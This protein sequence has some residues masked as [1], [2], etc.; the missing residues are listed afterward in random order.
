MCRSR[1]DCHQANAAEKSASEVARVN[2]RHILTLWNIAV[3]AD[4]FAFV[5]LVSKPL[6]WDLN[7][8]A[9]SADMRIQ[10]IL[11]KRIAPK[12]FFRSDPSSPL[13][14][15][16]LT[17]RATSQ[18]AAIAGRNLGSNSFPTQFLCSGSGTNSFNLR[19]I[20]ISGQH[21]HTFKSCRR[22]T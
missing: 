16:T 5:K 17:K 11:T 2:A 15:T 8:P 6:W 18:K 10:I 7:K 21:F 12:I 3:M 22:I 20:A 14:R 13:L 4:C 19:K 9:A 1:T